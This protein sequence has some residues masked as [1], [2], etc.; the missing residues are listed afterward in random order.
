MTIPRTKPLDW[1]RGAGRAPGARAERV[2]V[3]VPIYGAAA[4][5]ERCLISVIAATDLTRHALILVIDGPQE[6][7][8]E[9]V[10][11]SFESS[12]AQILRNERRCGFVESVNRGMRGSTRDVVLLNSDTIV[13]A[14]WLDKLI[15]AAASHGDIGTVTPLSNN[16]TLCSVPRPFEENLIP[17]GFD[18]ES[19]GAL[20]E[21][22]SARAYPRLPTGVGVCFY[23]RRALLDEIGFFDSERFG[24]GYGEEN[25]FCMRALAHGWLHVADDATFIAHA[26]HRSFGSSSRAL[27]RK[28]ARTL[29]RLHPAYMSTIARFMKED[30]LAP[31]RERITKALHDHA[32]DVSRRSD[33]QSDITSRRTGESDLRKTR[34]PRKI[35]HLVHGWPPFQHAGTELYAYWLVKQQRQWRDVS[36]FT[37][38]ADPT[39]AQGEGVDLADDGVRVRFVT[40]N[41]VQRDPFARNALR[42]PVFERSFERFI[43]EEKPQLIHIHHLAG[44]AFSL[45]RVARRL[46][47]PIV[48][49][50]QDW[51][52][53]CGR[54]NLFDFAW[55]RCSG[56]GLAKCARC[57]PMTGIAPAPLWN[58]VL[59][60]AR[61]VAARKA[62]AAADAFV[63]GSRFI[64]DDYLRA[65]L[66]PESVPAFVLP[67]GVETAERITRMP[68][69]RP[70]RFGFVGS[71]LPHKGLHVAAEAFRGID[72]AQATLHAWG[73]ASASP[74]YAEDVGAL[75]GDALTIEGTFAEDAKSAIF[76]SID[77]LLVPSIGLESFGLAAREAMARG[78]PVVASRDGA[79]LEM[80]EPG[81][82]GDLFPSGDASALRAIILR[83]IDAP[84]IIDGWSAQIPATKSIEEHAEEIE[85]VYETVMARR[86]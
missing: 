41:F 61:R 17:S 58:R 20:V 7:A 9:S 71:I 11:R 78:I 59:H 3:I 23:I 84:E 45:A 10:V 73:D 75:G 77:V 80:F 70:L 15:D 54:V 34:G 69:R 28:A 62:L 53:L 5:L 82:C 1:C 76:D 60:L 27:Q 32:Q 47:I 24:L 48:Y 49:Q 65:R 50:I 21:R 43:R 6:D 39:R 85:T 67:Y 44:H 68:R 30:P 33:S 86:R 4:D 81:V 36:V 72:R 18:A 35:V 57:A 37:R 46:E 52:S 83:L 8:V 26:G 31:V 63:M 13:T 2:D 74:A 51:W 12:T 56:P 64:H 19:F 79:L 16:A 66:L 14:G 55:Q 29:N 40:N 22:V 25:D 42:D 38:L